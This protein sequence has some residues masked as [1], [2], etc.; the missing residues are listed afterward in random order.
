MSGRPRVAAATEAVRTRMALDGSGYD[1]RCGTASRCST[2]ES[3]VDVR[4]VAHP[5]H[6]DH[7]LRYLEWYAHRDAPLAER[8]LRKRVADWL[9]DRADPA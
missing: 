8:E 2:G 6:S 3:G 9:A 7:V 1:R 4:A 5:A